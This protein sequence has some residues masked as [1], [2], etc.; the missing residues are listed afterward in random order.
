MIVSGGILNMQ[1]INLIEEVQKDICPECNPSLFSIPEVNSYLRNKFLTVKTEIEFTNYSGYEVYFMM[2][3]NKHKYLLVKEGDDSN[4]ILD[5]HYQKSITGSFPFHFNES[6]IIK[7]KVVNEK[8]LFTDNDLEILAGIIGNTDSFSASYLDSFCEN[9]GLNYTFGTKK[10]A[11]LESFKE[12]YQRTDYEKVVLFLENVLDIKNNYNSKIS[13]IYHKIK[14]ETIDFLNK[15]GFQYNDKTNKIMKKGKILTNIYFNKEDNFEEL[16]S[17][18]K[19]EYSNNT[20]IQEACKTLL[21][22]IRKTTGNKKDG[23]NL[24]NETFQYIKNGEKTKNPQFVINNFST[25]TEKTAQLGFYHLLLGSLNMFRHTTAHKRASKW[26]INDEDTK[27]I[28]GI[29]NFLTRKVRKQ[30]K[31]NPF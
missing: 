30:T 27:E 12:A 10:R 16:K 6:I 22:A 4:F 31:K 13:D 9:I 3:S 2:C 1:S 14:P 19:D 8:Y 25:D 26:K 7:K 21:D 18:I 29:L 15:I 23:I 5:K 28:L 11:L 24:I 20:N 17:D